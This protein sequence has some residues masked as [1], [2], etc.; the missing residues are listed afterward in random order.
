METEADIY[1]VLIIG[2]GLG[3]LL[4]AA[5]LGMEGYKVCVL[6]KNRQ[7]GG[8]LQSFSREKSLFDSGVHYI[9]GLAPGETLH[10]VFKY[11]GLIGTL[12]LEQMDKHV[13]DRI[14]FLEDGREYDMA[15]GYDQFI[16]TLVDQFP[17]ERPAIQ[18]YCDT[19]RD[20]CRRFPLYNLRNI[21]GLTE[22][23]PVLNIGVQPFIQSL[24]NNQRLQEV[25]AGNNLLYAGVAEK[26]PLYVHALVLNSYIE[27]S[28]KCVDGGS[29][30]TRLLLKTI[31]Q[32]GGELFN[33]ARVI[34]LKESD[35]R[36]LSAKLEDGREIGA[37]TFISNLHPQQTLELTDSRQLRPAFR[38][39]IAGLSNTISSFCVYAVLNP[40][41]IPYEKHNYYLHAKDGVWKGIDCEP[42]HWP[43]T[44]F[45][46]FSASAQQTAYASAMTLMTYMPYE[47]VEE[48]SDSFNTDA[49]PGERGTAYAAFKEAKAALL[50]NLVAK[51]FPQISESIQSIYTSSPLSYR[52]YIG[53]S[54]GSLYGVEKDFHDPMGSFIASRTKIPNLHLTGQ[55]LLMHGLMGVSMSALQT[56]GAFTDLD[57]L[58]EK[59]KDA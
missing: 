22:K 14:V 2:S 15:Q 53:T 18:T 47:W 7:Y 35:G 11:V 1:D 36:I 24:T 44:C 30:I 39:R 19:I 56:C 57:K 21:D 58:L 38:K 3:G 5:I 23:T 4:C 17:D 43:M 51:Y 54:D 27:S 59:I 41:T 33:H 40:G 25:L 10:Q 49:E 37:K 48:W 32:Q 45:L 52:D 9:G 16:D 29:Q 55:N 34:A 46:Y 42:E 13:F 6:E 26:T 12:P 8:C 28:W 50:I 20:I 31:R